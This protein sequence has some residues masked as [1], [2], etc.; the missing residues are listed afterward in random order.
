MKDVIDW[1]K[2]VIHWIK[3]VVDALYPIEAGTGVGSSNNLHDFGSE[4]W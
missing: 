3:Y 1:I 4:R 2:G